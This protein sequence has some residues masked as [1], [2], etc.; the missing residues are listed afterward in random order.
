MLIPRRVSTATT[1]PRLPLLLAYL[2]HAPGVGPRRGVDPPSHGDVLGGPDGVQN[3]EVSDQ[4]QFDVAVPTDALRRHDRCHPLYP[5]KPV[6]RP[7]WIQDVAIN[8]LA[9]SRSRRGRRTRRSWSWFVR[10]PIDNVGVQ[11]RAAALRTARYSADFVDLNANVGG[12]D[13]DDNPTRPAT[14]VVAR[15]R[16]PGHIGAGR[17]TRPTTCNQ[18]AIIDCRVAQPGRL[19]RRVPRVRH[20]ARLDRE[21]GTHANQ[22]IWEGPVPLLADSSCEL[23]SFIAMDQWLTAVERDHK[24]A[25]VAQ[26]IVRDKPSGLTDECFDGTGHKVSNSLL[27]GRRRQRR[28]DAAHGRRRPAH[29]RREQVPATAAESGRLRRHHVHRRSV[30]QLQQIYPNGVCNYSKPGVDQQPTVPWLTIPERKGAGDLRRQAA[31]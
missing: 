19:P 23:N 3:A 8:V 5:T 25:S 14:T 13:I 20:R 6:W 16:W 31:G 24:R 29:H 12:L 17:S 11:V 7:L 26:K 4:A 10:P 15:H 28:G 27:P 21:H 1:V 9:W 2:H 22:L 30:D 18:T